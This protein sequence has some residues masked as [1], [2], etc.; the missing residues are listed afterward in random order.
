MRN[1]YSFSIATYD[2]TDSC[3]QE[4]E[5]YSYFKDQLILDKISKVGVIYGARGIRKTT[6]LRQLANNNPGVFYHDITVGDYEEELL[7]NFLKTLF[8]GPGYHPVT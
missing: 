8:I 2:I 4:R 1:S 3:Y 5:I 6:F 7:Q